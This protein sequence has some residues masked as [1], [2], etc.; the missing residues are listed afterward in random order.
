[1]CVWGRAAVTVSPAMLKEL[2]RI[3]EESD[4]L[5]CV[6]AY[7]CVCV[8]AHACACVCAH[9]CACVRAYAFA[10][11]RLLHACTCVRALV[12]VCVRAGLSDGVTCLGRM[13]GCGRPPTALGARSS[14]L[15]WATSTSLSR[16]AITQAWSHIY[17]HTRTR[18]A[19]VPLCGWLAASVGNVAYVWACARVLMALMCACGCG[20]AIQTSKIGSLNEIQASKDPDGL[21][22]FYFLVQ[23]LKCL[24]FAAIALHFKASACTYL[25]HTHAQRTD[26]GRGTATDQADPGLERW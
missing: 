10:C 21:R 7:A 13:T 17:I 24:V 4:V 18:D 25:L 6:R 15:L 11:V 5:K 26:R 9:A 16:C 12:C 20:W 1:M 2:K 14:R 8:C 22:N 19:C 23:D 3:I